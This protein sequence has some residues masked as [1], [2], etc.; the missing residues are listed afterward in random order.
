V[1]AWLQFGR[2]PEVAATAIGDYRYGGATRE[3]FSRMPLPVDDRR[4]ECPPHL[5][6]WE[7]PRGDLL[8]P[9]AD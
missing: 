4:T 6:H 7:M 2:A 1:R 5:T 8:A 9:A 3:N